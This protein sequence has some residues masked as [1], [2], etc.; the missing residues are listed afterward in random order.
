MLRAFGISDTGRVRPSNEDCFAIDDKLALCVIADG[1]GG[2]NAGEV[3]S[4]MTV[5]AVTEFVSQWSSA[6]AADGDPDLDKTWP[7]GYDAHFSKDGNLLRTAIQIANVQI[8]EASSHSEEY[9]GMGTTIVAAR[10]S[11]GRL[12]VG[13]VGDSRLYLNSGGR[14]QAMT[15]DD[16]WLAAILS[17]NPDTDPAVFRQHPMRNALTA[18]VGALPRIDVHV[19][20]VALAAGDL[21][22]MSTD[23]VHGVLDDRRLAE[24]MTGDDLE[25]IANRIVVAAMDAGST[26]NC[27]AIVGRYEA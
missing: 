27:T 14:I 12:T 10:V 17:Q 3:A 20:D 15:R 13:H 16:S 7:F 24:L 1:M 22:L 23:G 19:A 26:D 9:A 6:E 21:M 25:A 11:G 18:V 8:L 2:H 5:D 4:R